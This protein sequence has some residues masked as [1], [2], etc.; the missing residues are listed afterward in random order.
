[1][2]RPILYPKKFPK[3]YQDDKDDSN[4]NKKTV[5][6]EQNNFTLLNFFKITSMH[7]STSINKKESPRRQVFMRLK[8]DKTDPNQNYR[9]SKYNIGKPKKKKK[10]NIKRFLKK[11]NNNNDNNKIDISNFVLFS[12][13][14]CDEIKNIFENNFIRNF[15]SYLDTNFNNDR[16]NISRRHDLNISKN[17]FNEFIQQIFELFIEK[18]LLN[19]YNK[20]IYISKNY[21]I[22]NNNDENNYNE[23][24]LLSYNEK[25]NIYLEY[26]PI[27]IQESNLFYPELSSTIVKFIKNFSKKKLN[28]MPNCALLLYKPSNDFSSYINKIRLICDQMGYNLLVKENEINKLMSFEKLKLI[29]QNYIIGSLKDKNKKY[30]EIIEAV[31]NTDKWKKFVEENDIYS[32]IEEEKIFVKNINRTQMINNI[33]NKKMSK[34]QSCIHTTQN[35]SKKMINKKN[36]TNDILSNTILTFIGHNSNEEINSQQNNDNNNSKAYNIAKDYQQ[37]ILEKFNK[38]R[39]LILFV[40][41]FEENED[42]IKYVNQINS[43]I[44]NSKSPIIIL[45]NNLPLFSNNLIIGNTSFQ[46]RY[47]PHQIE[48]EGII[49]K[50]NIIYITFLIIYFISFFPNFNLKKEIK[51]NDINNKDINNNFSFNRENIADNSQKESEN[52]DYILKKIKKSINEVFI[53]I[54]LNTYNNELFSS[55]ISLSNIISIKNNYELDNILVYLKNLFLFI[56]MDLKRNYIKQNPLNIITSLQNKVLQEIEDYKVNEDININNE[57]LLKLNDICEQNSFSDYEYG[58]IDNIGEKEYEA[59]MKNYGINNG[60]DFNKE[61]FFYINEFYEEFKD[62]QLFNYISNVEV[63]ERIVEDY[64]FYHTY[65]NSSDTILNHS[66]INKLNI[67]LTQI[68]I[69]ERISPEDISRFIGIKNNKRN[70]YRS[71]NININHNNN[72]MKEKISLLNKLFNKCSL[73]LFNKY[74]NAHI[75]IN[76]YIEFLIDN[77]KYYIPDKLLFFNYYNDYY[78]MEQINSEQKN[79]FYDDEEDEYSDEYNEDEEY[80]N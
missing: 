20:L 61:S 17:T 9:L 35:L 45:T 34:S 7:K 11:P 47:I 25:E 12:E 48:N 44:P 8:R 80:S 30:L 56:N 62:K 28:K 27:N 75:G 19:T 10:L 49:Q 70:N 58:I 67:M 26:S 41:N 69:N 15:K 57:D 32:L 33:R 31:A 52:N 71:Q 53:N 79:R 50:E 16:K 23:V 55:F 77:K 64:K 38:R 42:N 74:I 24:E 54:N 72:K 78:L 13:K 22:D 4:S 73:E 21:L 14:Y 3:K 2:K 1:M 63:N 65:Y 29:N 43:L 40:D 66:D 18:Y 39:N 51:L 59:K 6:I 60:V 76:Y 5:S 68:I 36:K 46:T 37:N